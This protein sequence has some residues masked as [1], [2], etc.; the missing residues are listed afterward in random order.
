MS[1]QPVL[2]VGWPVRFDD[3][4]HRLPKAQRRFAAPINPPSKLIRTDIYK[5][6]ARSKIARQVSVRYARERPSRRRSACSDSG[7]GCRLLEATVAVGLRTH[8]QGL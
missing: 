1:R 8:E 2:R 7:A 5:A 6:I 3:G 4:R